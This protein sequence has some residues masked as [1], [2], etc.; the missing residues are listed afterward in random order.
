MLMCFFVMFV[1]CSELVILPKSKVQSRP[2]HTH[3]Y[4]HTH[5][6]T[7]TLT[8]T[9]THTHILTHASTHAHT[10]SLT[11]THSHTHT[12]H[13][14]THSHSHYAHFLMNKTHLQLVWGSPS[15]LWRSCGTETLLHCLWSVASGPRH[16]H[17]GSMWVSHCD[18]CCQLP[19]L[20][21]TKSVCHAAMSTFSPPSE[22]RPQVLYAG[23]LQN[24]IC[25][26]LV[27]LKLLTFEIC[28]I[29]AHACTRMHAYIHACTHTHTHTRAPVS[30]T[31]LTLPTS[32]TV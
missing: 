3:T 10:H 25:V 28:F 2:K 19:V 29:C 1:Q 15:C 8:H 5:S 20:Q 11:L 22:P 6:L 23:M 17:D 32:S 13:T 27:G 16:R 24:Q 30:Y 12:T 14:L 4:T 31:H 18:C 7:H 26:K 9:H 21:N